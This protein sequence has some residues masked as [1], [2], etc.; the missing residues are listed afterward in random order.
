MMGMIGNKSVLVPP[1]VLQNIKII[2]IHDLYCY[3]MASMDELSQENGGNIP[4]FQNQTTDVSLLCGPWH[5]RRNNTASKCK[6]IG[7]KMRGRGEKEIE[8]GEERAL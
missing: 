3:T 1:N 7:E 2:F 5:A 8:R 6:T 4:I